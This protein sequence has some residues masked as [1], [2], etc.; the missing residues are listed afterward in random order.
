[1]LPLPCNELDDNGSQRA[2]GH[3]LQV[4]V[5]VTH[6]SSDL[7]SVVHFA[8]SLHT[9]HV[10]EDIE[11]DEVDEVD[12]VDVV[13]NGVADVVLSVGLSFCCAIT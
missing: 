6:L 13:D 7:H 2:T 12:V 8:I 11:F 4:L 1:L 10:D 9:T 5:V 3:A